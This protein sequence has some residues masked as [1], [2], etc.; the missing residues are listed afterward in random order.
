MSRVTHTHKWDEKSHYALILSL[1]EVA[2]PNKDFLLRVTEHMQSQGFN[3]TFSGVKYAPTILSPFP[4]FRRRRLPHANP[5][6]QGRLLTPPSRPRQHIQKLRRTQDSPDKSASNDGGSV[7]S[8]PSKAT[9]KRKA[10]ARAPKA[11]LARSPAGVQDSDD[12]DELPIKLEYELSGAD[13]PRLKR[14]KKERAG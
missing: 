11:S 1:I 12:Q 4:K 13:E 3:T 14:P 8:T 7:P 6:R 9:P 5:R 10:R 2:R